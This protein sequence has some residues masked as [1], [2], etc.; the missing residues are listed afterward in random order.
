MLDFFIQKAYAAG[1]NPLNDSPLTFDHLLSNITSQ[2]LVPIEFL[3][4]GLAVI[5]F[6]WGVVVFIQNA[7]SAEKRSEGFSHMVWGIVGLFI[8]VAARGLINLI[9]VF[10]GLK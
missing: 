2:I 5:Y 9:L 8:M 1:V 6:L 10:M 4:A 3:L 7:E